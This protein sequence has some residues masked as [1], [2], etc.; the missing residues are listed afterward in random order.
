MESDDMDMGGMTTSMGGM[1]GMGD[2]ACMK[3]QMWTYFH[4]KPDD[5]ILF[6]FWGVS[7]A[8]GIGLLLLK[9]TF[10]EM[11]WSS[12]IIF[13]LALIPEFIK[14]M[15]WKMEQRQKMDGIP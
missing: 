5:T 7:N 10:L 8:G 11:V 13:G 6:D 3:H 14:F 4:V 1:G 12:F 9:N 15:R 2:M